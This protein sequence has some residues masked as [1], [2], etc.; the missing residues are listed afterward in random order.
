MT[1][2]KTKHNIILTRKEDQELRIYFF[3]GQRGQDKRVFYITGFK[4]EDA[5]RTLENVKKEYTLIFTNQSPTVRRF[6]RELEIESLVH[7]EMI[8]PRPLEIKENEPKE[9]SPI[10]MNFEKFRSGLLF[11]ANEKDITYQGSTDQETLK[12]IISGLKY[13][14]PKNYA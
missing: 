8:T 13:E 6:M 7:Q 2:E 4:L 14:S 9:S 10:E 12:K 5:F 1:N 3:I 11:C